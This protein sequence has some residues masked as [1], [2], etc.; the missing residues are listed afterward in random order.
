[1]IDDLMGIED[2]VRPVLDAGLA[3]LVDD[4]FKFDENISFISTPGHTPSHVS[5]QIQSKG[6][7]ALISGD[8][9]YHPCQIERPEWGNIVDTYPDEAFETRKKILSL[10]VDTKTLLLGSHFANPVGG[11]V[12]TESGKQIFRP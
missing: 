4:T 12:V 11:Y 3:E 10:L 6:E 9:I 2:S 8:F 1:M 5:V 7:K